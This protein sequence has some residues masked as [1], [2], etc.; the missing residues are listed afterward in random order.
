MSTMLN[1]SSRLMAK[2]KKLT[3]HSRTKKKKS[4]TNK[5]LRSFWTLKK[6]NTKRN[7]PKQ[8]SLSMKPK[9]TLRLKSRVK[10]TRETAPEFTKKPKTITKTMACKSTTTLSGSKLSQPVIGSHTI[11]RAIGKS[12]ILRVYQLCL[13]NYL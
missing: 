2:S 4:S 7:T 6:R 1:E 9:M 10:P 3:R 11:K 12:E 8:Q 5:R 13:I